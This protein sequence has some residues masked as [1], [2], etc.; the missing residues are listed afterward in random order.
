[1]K[2]GILVSALA[3]FDHSAQAERGNGDIGMIDVLIFVVRP[4]GARRT[5][6]PSVDASLDGVN[7]PFRETPGNLSLLQVFERDGNLFRVVPPL[8]LR[9]L[10]IS[11]AVAP[12]AQ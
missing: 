1:M 7:D 12:I 8:R 11:E 4:S 9:E 10:T 2:P 5:R 6:M 3:V